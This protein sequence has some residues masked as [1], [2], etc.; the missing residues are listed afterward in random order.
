MGLPTPVTVEKPELM[1][2]LLV[3]LFV[4]VSLFGGISQIVSS[5]PSVQIHNIT[6]EYSLTENYLSNN[7]CWYI[8][9]F[10]GNLGETRYAYFCATHP[11]NPAFSDEF[12]SRFSPLSENS[13]LKE[14][15]IDA[16][17]KRMYDEGVKWGYITP[18]PR[19]EKDK[20]YLE[21]I[22]AEKEAVKAEE[23][24]K[25]AKQ[26]EEEEKRESEIADDA[27][28]VPVPTSENSNDQKDD[29]TFSSP[30]IIE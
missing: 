22:T 4:V 27:M 1:S 29:I 18:K 14:A 23:D 12:V 5:L 8:N 2:Y 28:N 11:K 16:I 13:G 30:I 26:R 21:K 24:A 3:P 17:Y 10:K 25:I 9:S 7:K 15:E 6:R 19:N 20:A